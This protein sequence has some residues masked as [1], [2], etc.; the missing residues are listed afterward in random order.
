MRIRINFASR[1]YILARKV[2]VVLLLALAAA[3]SVF[4]I[5]YGDYTSAQARE[6][7]LTNQLKLHDKIA[8]NVT[9][10]LAEAGKKAAEN[11]V[12]AAVMQAQFADAA[13]DR[14]VF[15]WTEFLNR[16]EE[17]VPDGVGIGSIKPDFSTL[18][19]D[20]SGTAL[21]MDRLTEFMDRMTKSPY[22]EDIPPIFHTT[23]QVADKDIGMSLQI[24]NLKIR[25]SPTSSETVRA[26]KAIPATKAVP[27]VPAAKAAKGGQKH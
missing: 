18:D 3:A 1:E 7:V 21:S 11:D 17:V 12:K 14:R 10:K 16:L 8:A 15:S 9:A 13:I 19:M 6:A 22:F 2:Y 25:Y 4:V 27:T 5:N 20:I 24:F 26:V 23:E